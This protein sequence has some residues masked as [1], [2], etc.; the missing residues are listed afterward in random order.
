MKTKQIFALVRVALLGLTLGGGA[1]MA[2]TTPTPDEMFTWAERNHSAVF[3]AGPTTQVIPPY[4]LRAYR[5]GNYL[6]IA[7]GRI[8]ALGPITNNQLMEV[9]LLSRFTCEIKPTT[10]GCPAPTLSQSVDSLI[11]IWRSSC[12]PGVA[13]DGTS[14][15][16][17]LT[18]TRL[19]Q[20]GFN[21]ATGSE[22]FKN[23]TCTGTPDIYQS[24]NRGT[25]RVLRSVVVQGRHAMHVESVDSLGRRD[26]DLLAVEGN[27]YFFGSDDGP[28]DANGFPSA[29]GLTVLVRQ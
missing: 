16:R 14:G 6:G 18:I 21:W 11:G 3:P 9:G 19:D 28:K 24:L 27:Q 2:Q 7:D 22:V 15:S 1:A 25:S 8:Y 13:G 26:L 12:V 17:K 10:A 5:T 29:F 23:G 20:L 4:T